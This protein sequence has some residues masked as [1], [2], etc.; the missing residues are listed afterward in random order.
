MQ[1]TTLLWTLVAFF[2]ASIL[3]RAVINATEDSPVLV[4]IALELVV[5][6]ALVGLI[7]LLVR[8]SDRG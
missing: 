1:R 5:L 2:G 4:T 3:F 6:G 8:R 7:V